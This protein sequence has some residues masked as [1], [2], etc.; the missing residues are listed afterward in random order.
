MREWGGR[1]TVIAPGM[2]DTAFFDD[3]QPTK[4]QPEDVANAVIFAL[5]QPATSAVRE[6]LPDAQR[7][8]FV[9]H[10][11][12]QHAFEQRQRVARKS[13]H[14]GDAII[15]SGF[16]SAACA[17]LSGPARR[18]RC[19]R[20]ARPEGCVDPPTEP[21]SASPQSAPKLAAIARACRNA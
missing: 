21:L 19:G 9:Q 17:R 13:G 3:P 16:R 12:Q 18:Q 7:L 1:C 6:N 10:I 4:I 2:V 8:A 5:E 14:V 15:A 11:V 20:Q